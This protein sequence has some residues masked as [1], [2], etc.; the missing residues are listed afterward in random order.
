V[1]FLQAHVGQVVV[2]PLVDVS[3]GL[4][5]VVVGEAVHLVDEHLEVDV[6][7]DEVRARHRGVQTHQRLHVVVLVT[8]T[9]RA[10]RLRWIQQR[11]T[12]SSRLRRIE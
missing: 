4:D 9:D 7:V 12:Q 10:S 11:R 2:G 6:G 8:D 5:L 1:E 3:L